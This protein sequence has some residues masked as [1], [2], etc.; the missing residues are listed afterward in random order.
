MSAI[1]ATIKPTVRQPRPALMPP[2]LSAALLDR[3]AD[4]ELQQGHHL[5]AEMLAAR[6]AELRGAAQ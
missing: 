6:A 4:A 3:L 2:V 1:I 5:A